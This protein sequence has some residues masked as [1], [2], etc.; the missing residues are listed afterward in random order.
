L[1]EVPQWQVVSAVMIIDARK[2]GRSFFTS[3]AR[4][5]FT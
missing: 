4:H 1:V 3:R 5:N 2:Y